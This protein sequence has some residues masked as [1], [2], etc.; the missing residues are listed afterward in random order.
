MKAVMM[1]EV[2]PGF[3]MAHLGWAERIK[4]KRGL[5]DDALCYGLHGVG[6]HACSMGWTDAGE[7]AFG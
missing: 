5:L 4:V 2:V 1:D 3:D 6:E 7:Y